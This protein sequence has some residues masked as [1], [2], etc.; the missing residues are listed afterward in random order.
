MLYEFFSV[1]SP[2]SVHGCPIRDRANC[3]VT[4]DVAFAMQANY[5]GGFEAFQAWLHRPY[6][7]YVATNFIP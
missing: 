3:D 2:V 5:F 1:S 6:S 4:R 7:A